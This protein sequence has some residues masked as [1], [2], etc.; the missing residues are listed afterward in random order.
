MRVLIATTQVPF[1]RGGAEML[2][3]GLR[4]AMIAAGHEAEIM[5][6]P[7]KWYPADVMA[8]QL[9]AARLLDLSEFSGMRIDRVVGLKFPAYLIP[10]PD[11]VLWLVHQHRAA[12]DFW[13]AGHSDLAAMPQGRA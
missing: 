1:V 4:D 11:R 6:F 13:D 3:E 10:H 2:A 7:F 8:A 9:L 12:Y 5:A